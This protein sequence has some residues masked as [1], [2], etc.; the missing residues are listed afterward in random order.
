MPEQSWIEFKLGLAG[1]SRYSSDARSSTA[2]LCALLISS[3]LM[4]ELAS[5]SELQ[6]E[7]KEEAAALPRRS[8]CKFLRVS[9][10]RKVRK[11]SITWRKRQG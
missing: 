2:A 9:V 6:N 1:A 3:L 5:S 8:E 4:M 7:R 11:V 10:L